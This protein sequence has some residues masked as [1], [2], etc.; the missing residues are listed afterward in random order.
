MN[1][2][3]K[4]FFVLGSIALLIWLPD[5]VFAASPLGTTTGGGGR[6]VGGAPAPGGVGTTGGGYQVVGGGTASIPG[7]IPNFQAGG[8]DIQPSFTPVPTD[9]SMSY[10]GQIF[11]TV[12]TV[13]HGTSGQMLG[14]LFKVFN[15]GILVV[16][17]IF[18]IYTIIMTVLNT[19]HEGEFMGRKWNSAWIAIRTILGIGLLVPSATT[20]Y[21]TVQVIVMWIVIQGVGFANMAWYSALGYLAQGGQV[22]TP[23]STDTA[24]MVDLVGNV[25]SMQ[26]C[27]YYAQNVEQQ[28]QKNLQQTQQQQQAQQ[29]ASATASAPPPPVIQNVANFTP[30]F[31]VF[32]DSSPNANLYNSAV[33]FPGNGYSAAG[34]QDNQC[35]QISFGKNA[36]Q[37]TLQSDQKAQTL[38]AAIQQIMLDTD[39]YA[40]QIANQVTNNASFSTQVQSA[41]V[42]GAADWVNVTLPLTTIGPSL[43]D[44]LMLGYFKTAAEQGWI[45]AGRYYYALGSISQKVSAVASVKVNIDQAP[46]GMTT[47]P[48]G[49][50]ISFDNPPPI[51]VDGMSVLKNFSPQNKTT[52]ANML[53][54]Q[55]VT[56]FVKNARS[57]ANQVDQAGKVNLNIGGSGILAFLLAPITTI[58]L[59]LIGTITTAVG[60]PI[61]ILQGFG[62]GFIATATVLWLGGTVGVF[63]LGTASS[64]LSS[65]NP[66]G[67]GVEDALLAFIPAFT[68]F[69]LL[70]FVM[71]STLAFYV[72][73]IPFIIFVFSA[74]GWLI[75]VIESMV[76]APLVALGITHPEGHDLLGKSEQAIMMLMSVFLRPILMIIGL[77]AGMIVS[78]VVLRFLNSG[79]FG[80]VF[81]VGDFNIFAF[82]AVL[83]I[84]CYLVVTIVNQAFSLIYVIPDRVMKWLGVSEQSTG[85]QEALQSSKQASEQ[86]LG[87]VQS[88]GG[89][90][91]SK[92]GEQGAAKAK[93]A[94]E[95]KSKGELSG[96]GKQ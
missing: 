84:Y 73:L 53:G 44:A 32:W 49:T 51:N 81:D 78:R 95:T 28:S 86:Y 52:L 7:W 69:I 63:A 80:I 71:G 24:S 48:K 43:G 19:A 8:L 37:A 31:T 47:P 30:L 18:L 12:G 5:Q 20:G 92:I 46:A 61:L 33:K 2:I 64:I 72:P 57:V 3:I 60:D 77:F 10:L 54:S 58:L 6:Q 40:K 42:G 23:P 14:Q 87:G 85:A 67:Y 55:G 66:L 39:G 38:K 83:V 15:I 79:F 11:G 27:M 50:Y 93:L 65:A 35:G 22:Y 59:T 76:A 36:N 62:Y 21:S 17:G 89:Q 29:A 70:F 82:V 25:M 74:I 45:M 94:R 16:A 9:L 13:L 41:I 96:T 4:A 68:A 91:G 56:S 26:V 75:T 34:R 88:M 90:V 1:K